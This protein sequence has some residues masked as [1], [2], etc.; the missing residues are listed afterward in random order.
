MKGG[1]DLTLDADL[2]ALPKADASACAF[3]EEPVFRS[4][5]CAPHW[6]DYESWRLQQVDAGS[7]FASLHHYFA[8]KIRTL[9]AEINASMQTVVEEVQHMQKR[10]RE[11]QN[12]Q[13]PLPHLINSMVLHL[14]KIVREEA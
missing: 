5:L 13:I 6:D 9:R 12:E 7:G 3:C 10:V 14:G 4:D 11:Y 2:Y 1:G 8:F